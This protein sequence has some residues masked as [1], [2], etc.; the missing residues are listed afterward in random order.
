MLTVLHTESSKGWGG[1]EQRTLRE[2]CGLKALGQRP[3]IL[4]PAEAELGRRAAAA[5]IEVLHAPMRQS[6]DLPSVFRVMRVIARERV[7]VVNTHSGR[8]SFLAGLAGRLS[9]RRP[10]I[11]RTR[12]L[13]LPLTSKI[14][15]SVL[16]H[17]VVTVS[18]YVRNYL[19]GEGVAPAQLT[20]IPTG[21]DLE[22]FSAGRAPATLRQELGLDADVPLI[23]TV[24]ILRYRKGHHI[25]LEA[26]PQ[27][28]A[29]FPEARFVFAGNGPQEENIRQ[30][31][32]RLGLA[33]RVIMLGLRND[34]PNLL[35]AFD[36]FVLPTLQEALGT[37]F[38]EAMAMGKPVIG[39]GVDGVGEVIHDGINGF[40]VA[41]NDPQQ[42]AERIITLLEDRR[43]AA[44]MGLAGQEIVRRD[45]SVER[46][47]E[48]MLALYRELVDGRGR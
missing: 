22:R 42:L 38:L 8:D 37:S 32:D 6:F 12:H 16:P 21:I 31:I 45:F 27:V 5:G 17:R 15:Y 11:V 39:C 41:P 10:V 46:M 2:A 13:A 43:L 40:L 33:S 35:H 4:C 47:C 44:T 23:G 30:A 28:L 20:A 3:L 1:Q 14:S 25:L 7:D 18:E 34:I 26:I 48:R 9:G 36:L 29:R 19:L 24:A